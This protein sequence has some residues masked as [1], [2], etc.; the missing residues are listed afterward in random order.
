M[1]V[2]GGVEPARV[3]AKETGEAFFQG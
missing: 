3:S 1:G 2:G